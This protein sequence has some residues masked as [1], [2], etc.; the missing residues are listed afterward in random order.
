MRKSNFEADTNMTDMVY[1]FLIGDCCGH[2]ELSVLAEVGEFS[3]LFSVM[4]LHFPLFFILE[5]G[6]RLV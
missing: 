3:P 2:I 4:V 5:K 6:R 1:D